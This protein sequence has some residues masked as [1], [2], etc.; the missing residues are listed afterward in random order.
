MWL[1]VNSQHG[2]ILCNN[3]NLWNQLNGG[4]LIGSFIKLQLHMGKY[5]TET[6]ICI[7]NHFKM[8]FLLCV[9]IFVQDN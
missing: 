4:N 9:C 5:V 2:M 6:K 8:N 1:A 7:I 3:L